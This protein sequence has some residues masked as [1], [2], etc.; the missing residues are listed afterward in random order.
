METSSKRHDINCKM[1][2]QQLLKLPETNQRKVEK[3]FVK[4]LPTK[5]SNLLT[6]NAPQSA[7]DKKFPSIM[8][9]K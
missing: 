5:R 7:T 6:S 9:G 1:H 2:T 4:T 8:P 3:K